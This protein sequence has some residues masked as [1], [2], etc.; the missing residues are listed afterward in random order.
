MI[1]DKCKVNQ[2]KVDVQNLMQK[3]GLLLVDCGKEPYSQLC[4]SQPGMP[5]NFF[6][7]LFCFL[8]HFTV[9]LN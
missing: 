1:F 6:F 2:E 5:F 3:L 8:K 9:I 4:N 7:L